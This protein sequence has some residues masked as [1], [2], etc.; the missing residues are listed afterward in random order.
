MSWPALANRLTTQDFHVKL[1]PA[2]VQAATLLRQ[3]LS[4]F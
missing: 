3:C 4:E 2:S 1:P